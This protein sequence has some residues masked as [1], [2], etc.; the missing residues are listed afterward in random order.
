VTDNLKKYIPLCALARNEAMYDCSHIEAIDRICSE[1]P[2]IPVL[3][4]DQLD[5]VTPI[6]N[7]LVEGGITVLEVTLRTPIALEAIQKLKQEL[8]EAKIGAGTVI[9]PDQFDAAVAAGADFI[10]TPG[11]S[12]HLLDKGSNSAIPLLPGVQ[13]LSELMLGMNSGYRRFK[14]FPAEVAGGINALKAFSGPIPEAKFCPTGGIN[15]EKAKDYLKLNNVMCVGGSWLTPAQA[16]KDGNWEAIYMLAK[17]S[18]TE[19]IR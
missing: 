10:V 11:I 17:Q 9:N 4:F 18:S 2:V 13:T 1:S 5:Q 6:A 15:A 8:P 12:Q 3:V 7:A 14:F 16:I 19:L